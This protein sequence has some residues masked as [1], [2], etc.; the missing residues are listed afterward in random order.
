[1]KFAVLLFLS[2]N[3]LLLSDCFDKMFLSLCKSVCI[4]LK[5]NLINNNYISI[6]SKPKSKS[7]PRVVTTTLTTHPLS[8]I[9]VKDDKIYPK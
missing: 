5:D 1:M 3:S 7:K 2:L 8:N 9:P 6:K 4:T